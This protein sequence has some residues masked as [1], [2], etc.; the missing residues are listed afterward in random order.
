VPPV[1]PSFLEKVPTL[2]PC[3]S[4]RLTLH[5]RIW[6]RKRAPRCAGSPR[7]V[8]SYGRLLLCGNGLRRVGPEGVE[9]PTKGL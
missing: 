6:P 7:V 8:W 2:V 4:Q 1:V 3:T 9:P 5:V